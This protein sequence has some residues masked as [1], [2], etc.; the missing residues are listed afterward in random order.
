MLARILG[1]FDHAIDRS[2][3]VVS[4]TPRKIHTRLPP[5]TRRM[6]GPVPHRLDSSETNHYC[7]F[8]SV[9]YFF[10]S[11]GSG[12]E[13]YLHVLFESGWPENVREEIDGYLQSLFAQLGFEP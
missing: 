13:Y 9:F 8:S 4:Q 10:V 1:C 3:R 2:E 11:S 12:F 5:P 7:S 6:H